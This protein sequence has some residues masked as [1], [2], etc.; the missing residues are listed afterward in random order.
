MQEYQPLQGAFE[1]L[2]SMTRQR[3]EQNPGCHDWDHT[4]RVL[5][6]ARAIARAEG[7]AMAVVEFAAV[8]HDVGRLEE[9]NDQGKSCHARIGARLVPRLLADVGVED[10]RFV[11][12]VRNCVLSH[13]YRRRDGPPPQTLE[14]R[15]VYDADKLDSMGAVGV[16]RAFH[17]AGRIGARLHNTDAEALAGESYGREDSAYREFLVKLRH[18]HAALL[19]DEGRRLGAQRHAFMVAFFDRLNRECAMNG[20]SPVPVSAPVTAGG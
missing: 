13:R 3:F 2:V 16:G 6:N 9:L 14:A 18:L 19:T 7:A 8:L 4:A 12:H 10:A 15:T 20:H 1:R 11:G 17:F 5:T